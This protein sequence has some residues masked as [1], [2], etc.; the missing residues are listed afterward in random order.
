MSEG[1]I[2]LVA[3]EIV[4]QARKGLDEIVYGTIVAVHKDIFT[5][6]LPNGYLFRGKAYE[7]QKAQ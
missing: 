7:L 3:G 6:L 4:E 2:V 5:V 1:D